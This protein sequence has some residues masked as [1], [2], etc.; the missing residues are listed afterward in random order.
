MREL[1]FCCRGSKGEVWSMVSKWVVIVKVISK[2]RVVTG[3]KFSLNLKFNVFSFHF[4][5]S[6]KCL[7]YEIQCF[8][9]KI[10]KEELIVIFS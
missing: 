10:T 2:V 5:V 9:L 8:D 6:N 3:R 4:S 7:Q 1:G